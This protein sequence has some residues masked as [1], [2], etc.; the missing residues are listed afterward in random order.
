MQ[1][2]YRTP[3]SLPEA[4]SGA[5][6]GSPS[7][8]W[9]PDTYGGGRQFSKKGFQVKRNAFS[10]QGGNAGGNKIIDRTEIERVKGEEQ[11]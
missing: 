4:E 5:Y 1:A 9:Q 8:L 10:T 2:Q 6:P 3:L 11:Q 7:A